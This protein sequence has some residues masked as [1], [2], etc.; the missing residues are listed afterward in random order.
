MIEGKTVINSQ[1]VWV[2]FRNFIVHCNYCHSCSTNL[3][4]RI[5]FP[6]CLVGCSRVVYGKCNRLAFSYDT[7]DNFKVLLELTKALLAFK[8]K[9]V[10]ISSIIDEHIKISQRNNGSTKGPKYKPG[11]KQPLTNIK[12]EWIRSD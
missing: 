7:I 9:R 2:N 8:N 11:R 6:C 5:N 12:K 3:R 10:E 4:N 1:E